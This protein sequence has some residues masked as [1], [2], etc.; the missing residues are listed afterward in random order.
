MIRL[1]IVLVV[2]LLLSCN[3]QETSNSTVQKVSE[4][5]AEVGSML[6]LSDFVIKAHLQMLREH[7]YPYDTAPGFYSA[8]LELDY[9]DQLETFQN[10]SF[11]LTKKY[12]LNKMSGEMECL[13][14]IKS[15]YT[16][17]PVRYRV[18][19]PYCVL[20]RY[21]RMDDQWRLSSAFN[22][23]EDISFVENPD[24]TIDPTICYSS[25]CDG[26]DGDFV[27]NSYLYQIRNNR[28]KNEFANEGKISMNYYE[29]NPGEITHLIKGDTIDNKY[30][31]EYTADAV[32]LEFI[33]THEI[34]IFQRFQN[35]TL[36]VRSIFNPV[37]YKRKGSEFSKSVLPVI[38]E[39]YV[40]PIVR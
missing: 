6:S 25:V 24:E 36:F 35:D 1:C 30:S 9:F 22:I 32:R 2:S 37:S 10:D 5:E 14:H 20:M 3:S 15:S 19:T 16:D 34:T 23:Y 18:I 4:N 28:L 40:D 31:V 11:I 13:V 29:R 27:C 12:G 26:I 7:E 38:E 33:I 8:S 39:E 17:Y 21:R